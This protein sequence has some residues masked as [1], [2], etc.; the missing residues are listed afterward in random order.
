MPNIVSFPAPPLASSSRA[1]L[2]GHHAGFAMN[3]TNGVPDLDEAAFEEMEEEPS[4]WATRVDEGET[5]G[6]SDMDV[7]EPRKAYVGSSRGQRR[8]GGQNWVAEE[9]EDDESSDEEDGP[10]RVH[11]HG[12][13][14]ASI[15]G[16]K[17]ELITSHESSCVA[18]HMLLISLSSSSS[19]GSPLLA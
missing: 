12:E 16:L 4:S 8:T 13:L 10:E 5:L 15:R 3:G 11:V 9:E 6:E 7:E 17:D 1:K 14:T 2:N 18:T 19:P